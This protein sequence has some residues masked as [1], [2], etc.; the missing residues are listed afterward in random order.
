MSDGFYAYTDPVVTYH[1][2]QG[3]ETCYD[4]SIQT[5]HTD[6]IIIFAGFHFDLASIPRAFWS[7]GLAPFSLGITAPL[8]HD[9]CYRNHLT[10]RRIVDRMFR[11]IQRLGGMGWLRRWVTWV[12]VR[13]F[14]GFAW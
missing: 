13:L 11:E 5:P 2:K 7:L 8:V 3:W 6:T 1:V 12:A 9:Y 10:D 14:G 4:W